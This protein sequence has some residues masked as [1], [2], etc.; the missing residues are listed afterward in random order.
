MDSPMFPLLRADQIEVKVKQVSKSG[1]ILLLYKTAR[2]D[3]DILDATVGPGRWQAAYAEIKGNLYCTISIWDADLGQWISKSNCGTESREDGEGNEKKGEASDALKRAGTTW[4]IGRELYTSPF[5]FASVPTSESGKGYALTNRYERFDVKEITYDDARRI[6][7]LTIV[8]SKGSVVFQTGK[9]AARGTVNAATDAAPPPP[10][11][12]TPDAAQAEPKHGLATPFQ[13][14]RIMELATPL[15][16]QA[17]EAKYGGVGLPTL[18]FQ[19][20]SEAMVKLRSA[21]QP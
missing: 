16:L 2:T 12:P 3:Y 18:T 7:T 13:L 5:V 21:R 4:G 19:R 11:P 10:A 8:D 6:A 17:M 1:A 9:Q 20:A 15:E 14:K